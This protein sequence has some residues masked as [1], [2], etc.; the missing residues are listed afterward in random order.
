MKNK[1][2]T[3]ITLVIIYFLLKNYIPYGNYI[4]YPIN[5][6][7]TL[8]HEFGHSFFA[9]ITGGSVKGVEINADGSGFAITAVQRIRDL[10]LAGGYIGSA[11]FGNILIYIGFKRSP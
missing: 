1:I 2:P 8:L 5:I 6:L 7:V 10:V 11:I 9:L 3:L 4:V